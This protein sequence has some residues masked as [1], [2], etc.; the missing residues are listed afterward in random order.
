V[1][2][3]ASRFSVNIREIPD[4]KGKIID[5]FKPGDEANGIERIS[6]GTWIFVDY[7]GTKGWVSSDFVEIL[8][9][10]DSL[11]TMVAPKLAP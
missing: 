11:P 8:L 5:S 10:V 2:R 7:D 3:N 6:D 1:V 4:I 9:P